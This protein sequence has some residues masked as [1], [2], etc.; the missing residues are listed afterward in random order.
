MI[1]RSALHRWLTLVLV[2]GMPM[3]TGIDREMVLSALERG[4]FCELL[5]VNSGRAGAA[6]SLFLTGVLSTFDASSGFR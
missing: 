1:G 5:A 3:T 2:S 6:P 4:R